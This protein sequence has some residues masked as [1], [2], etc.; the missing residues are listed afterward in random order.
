MIRLGICGCG[1]FVEQ[2]V[3]P[4]L[5]EVENVKVTAVH[6][7]REQRAQHIAQKFAI[8][9]VFDD[10]D[11]LVGSQEI[12]AVYI[13]SP[14]NCH[15][16]QTIKAAN[17][18]KHVLCEKPMGLDVAECQEMVDACSANQVKLAIGFCYPW[19]GAQQK[20]RELINEGRVGP[21]SYIH[22]SFNLA[23]YTAE[24]VGWRCDPKFSGGGPLMDLAPHL[25]HLGCFFLDDRV[26]SAMAYV[27]PEMTESQ[28]ETDVNALI[29]FSHGCR[30]A[31]DTS[32]VR[33]NAHNYTVVGSKGEIHAVDTMSWRAGGTVTAR[34]QA[35]ENTVPFNSTEAIAEEFRLFAAAIDGNAA[36]PA[37][38]EIGLH[39]QAVIDALYESGRTGRR[40]KV[41]S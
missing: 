25:V 41:Q 22:M 18:G 2:G 20:V 12:D 33:S 27:R 9:H 38:G 15:R 21:V 40:R 14:N 8:P 13:C 32:F 1:N 30:L 11:A 37:S 3:L 36:L 24:N 6:S 19:G 5:A 31:I 10:Y 26:E 35:G 28:V 34:D 17:A 39:V 16:V 23:S 29:E 4:L 7:S